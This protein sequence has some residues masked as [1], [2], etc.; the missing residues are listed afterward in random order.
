[1]HTLFQQLALELRH[2]LAY[3]FERATAAAAGQPQ[4]PQIVVSTWA[5]WQIITVSAAGCTWNRGCLCQAALLE[6][7]R[8]RKLEDTVRVS[9]SEEQLL[10]AGKWLS[11]EQQLLV[12]QSLTKYFASWKPAGPAA[13]PEEAFAYQSHLLTWLLTG[14]SIPVPRTS[15]L[16]KLQVGQ[17]LKFNA[18]LRVWE[19]DVSERVWLRSIISNCGSLPGS[20]W[21]SSRV[22]PQCLCGCQRRIRGLWRPG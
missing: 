10:A 9:R 1:M 2:I 14:G 21:L 5:A 15:M 11:R 13:T 20:T 19:I 18:E 8:D 3:C 17:T 4:A 6:M 7:G 16:C 22:R 12:V